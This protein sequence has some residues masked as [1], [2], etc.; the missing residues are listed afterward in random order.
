MDNYWPLLF[1]IG[2]IALAV[3]PVMM[4]QPSQRIR[5]L[6]ALRQEAAQRSIR[7]R[8][9]TLTLASEKKEIAVYSLLLPSSDTPKT[10]RASWTL[11][12]RDYAHGIN[13]YGQWEWANTQHTAQPEH[14]AALQSIVDTL[15]NSIVGIALSPTAVNVYWQEKQLTID[16][17][18]QLLI[19]C[20]DQLV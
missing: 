3:G 17:I 13:F 6:T 1:I 20:R 2:A 5:R 4:M 8:L 7:V 16:D 15:D 10:S 18:E 12:K 14:H 9:E 11:L 19:R